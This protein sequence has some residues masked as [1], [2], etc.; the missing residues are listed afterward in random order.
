LNY[1]LSHLLKGQE[2]KSLN[3][4]SSLRDYAD[5][6]KS[7][8]LVAGRFRYG[9]I[10][11]TTGLFLA[12]LLGGF[13]CAAPIIWSGNGH[14]YEFVRADGVQW[15][16]A[17][18][19]AA[20]M[21]FRGVAGHLATLTSQGENDFVSNLIVD[22]KASLGLASFIE[23]WLGA[24]QLDPNAPA[25][26]TWSWITGEPWQFTSWD[27][28]EPNDNG[29]ERYL[30]IW[31]PEGDGPLGRWNDQGGADDPFVGQNI[32]GYIVEY[33]VPEPDALVLA[34]MALSGFAMRRRRENPP[35]RTAVG[36]LILVVERVCCWPQVD[37]DKA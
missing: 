18:S 22:A 13:A 28:D 32:E 31:G 24:E 29:N 2:M 25:G 5:C 23:A 33:A 11:V 6:G 1:I 20:T 34:A 27:S 35:F 7:V 36:W 19:S 26:D 8:L 15:P 14:A 37:S 3:T 16:N 30:G 17:K 21:D 4:L 12:L 9:L 10:A